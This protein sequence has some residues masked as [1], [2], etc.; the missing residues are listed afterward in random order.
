MDVSE[1]LPHDDGAKFL[2]VP[3][4]ERWGHPKPVITQLYMG[5]YGPNGKSM[6]IG[7]VAG[8][9]KDHYSFYAALARAHGVSANGRSPFDAAVA[10][11]AYLH[12][13]SPEATTPGRLPVSPS[14]TMQL[15]HQKAAQNR[16]SLML[17]GKFNELL[18]SCGRKDRI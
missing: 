14:P 1:L 8:F 6:T 18:S 10:T 13:H 16:S 9:M 12:I 5:K 2:D 3:Y 17:Q 11:P 15:V 4:E 7:R